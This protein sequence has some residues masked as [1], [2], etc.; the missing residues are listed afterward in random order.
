MTDHTENGWSASAEAW[1]NDMGDQG[2]KGRGH[3]LDDPMLDRVQRAAPQNM[4]DIG[5]GEGRFCRKMHP[6]GIAPTGI[7]PTPEFIAHAQNCDPEGR[8]IKAEAEDLPFADASFDI[9]VF[10][11]TLI[12]I[13]DFRTAIQ[14]ATRVLRP[15]GRILVA[16]LAG[17]IT[18][19]R[20]DGWERAETG[21]R[22]H[23]TGYLKEDVYWTH[24]RGI[25][26]QNWHRPPR[27]YMQAFLAEGLTLT[28]YDE[29]AST[30]PDPKIKARYDDVAYFTL[31]EW[32]KPH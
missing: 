12:D 10:Y 21:S 18:A 25:R 22:V 1:I 7:D 23:L 13:P 6:L 20:H 29:P 24:W 4:L 9:A 17:F 19:A 32:Q 30:H 2:D 31:M 14:E 8:Y 5:C 26:I 3:V 28:Q 15:G 27:D 16:N 11:L